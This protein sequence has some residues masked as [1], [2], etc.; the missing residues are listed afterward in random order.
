MSVYIFNLLQRLKKCLKMISPKYSV[1][2]TTEGNV[3]DIIYVGE[4]EIPTV[5]MYHCASYS[6]LP[7]PLLIVLYKSLDT[8][9]LDEASGVP[10]EYA[11]Y[12]VNTLGYQKNIVFLKKLI[13]LKPKIQYS[14]SLLHEISTLDCHY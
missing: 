1:S 2:A 4:L 7:G 13:P 3:I 12:S 8:L 14:H 5:S 11:R 9:I 10:S 6:V